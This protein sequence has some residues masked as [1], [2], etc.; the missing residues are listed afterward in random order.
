MLREVRNKHIKPRIV[1]F[2]TNTTIT[3][4]SPVTF[5]TGSGDMNTVTASANGTA[6]L[7]LKEPFSR[8]SMVFGNV[9]GSGY[10]YYNSATNNASSFPFVL[11]NAAGSGVTVNFNGFVF[12]WDSTDVSICKAQR[13]SGTYAA[14]RIL[15][16]K[17]SG[18]TGTV[19]I[20]SAD[21][22]CSRTATGQYLVGLK[23]NSFA[24]NPV[25]TSGG[26]NFIPIITGC[27]VSSSATVAVRTA[28]S[29][30]AVNRGL[31]S[32]TTYN[33]SGSAADADFYVFAFGSMARSDAGKG[34][35]PLE[36]TQRRPRIIAGQITNTSG[37]PSL[38][39]GGATGGADFINLVD[40]GA[41]DFSVTF[42]EKFA[43]EP[44]V[45]AFTSLQRAQVHSASATG[46]RV[47]TK[48]A[49]G[50]N[51]DVDGVTNIFVI[52]SD[53]VSEY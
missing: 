45:F 31:T 12:G 26:A 29:Q 11:A 42:A 39:I 22:S 47:L 35:E 20:G 53:D 28:S 44:A 38:S 25:F 6:N 4:G 40:N 10:A 5:L 32:M 9:N 23:R 8:A 17:V 34:R 2:T 16:G 19:A 49:G 41:G 14:P 30:A 15:W 50:A 1:P 3:S 24:N 46:C 48:A 37:T 52:G 43:R 51:T 33:E 7:S 21:F 27:G 36:N 18:A 13:V